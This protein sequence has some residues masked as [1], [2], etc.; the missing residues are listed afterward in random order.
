MHPPDVS[1][2][3]PV[4][5][6]RPLLVVVS[7]PSGSGKS[8][9]AQKLL[10]HFPGLVFSIS[11]TTRKPRPGEVDG[12]DYHFLS[13]EEFERRVRED[14]FIEH[15]VVH[16]RRYGTLRESVRE[17]MGQGSDALLDIDP[18]GAEQVRAIVQKASPD[19]PVRRGFVDIFIVPPSRE[20]LR[21]R[22]EARG[23]ETPEDIARR[24]SV[25]AAEMRYRP[26]YRYT[27]VN[28]RLDEAFDRLKAIVLAEHCRNMSP[29]G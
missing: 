17:T 25:A 21:R 18:Q 26:T 8:T 16:G 5:P 10:D 28:D 23:T 6:R 13:E 11:C 9:L 14:A 29:Q 3:E 19:D 7:A 22:L 20:E 4:P 12:R 24:L 2:P 15:A 27:V 1:F